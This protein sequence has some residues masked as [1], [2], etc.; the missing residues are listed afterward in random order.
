MQYFY[1][2]NENNFRLVI[3]KS[4]SGLNKPIITEKEEN[5]NNSLISAISRSRRMIREYSLCNDFVY[6]FT[7]TV[8]SAVCNRYSLDATQ[9]KIRYIIKEFVKRKNKD[10]KYVFITEKHKDGAY[11]FHRSLY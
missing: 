3:D 4:Y 6:F 8:N 7:S 9:D 2:Y 5:N 1:Q 10:F 11:H